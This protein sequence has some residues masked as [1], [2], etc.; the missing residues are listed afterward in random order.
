MENKSKEVSKLGIISY[1]GKVTNFVLGLKK[2][3]NEMK[4][5]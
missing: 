3:I 1:S 2:I 4:E 5:N